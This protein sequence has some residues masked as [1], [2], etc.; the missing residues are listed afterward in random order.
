MDYA[1]AQRLRPDCWKK[2]QGNRFKMGA[3]KQNGVSSLF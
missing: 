3:G 2:V 1:T